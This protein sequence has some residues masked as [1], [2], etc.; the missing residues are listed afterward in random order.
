M[1]VKFRYHL[2]CVQSN[3]PASGSIW[4]WVCKGKCSDSEMEVRSEGAGRKWMRL[5]TA[6]EGRMSLPGPETAEEFIRK[7]KACCDWMPPESA[8]EIWR[9]F[10]SPKDIT[11]PSA[12]WNAN[13]HLIITWNADDYTEMWAVLRPVSPCFPSFLVLELNA[14]GSTCCFPQS[15]APQQQLMTS[16]RNFLKEK[17]RDDISVSG[18][19][20]IN[21]KQWWKRQLHKPHIAFVKRLICRIRMTSG[22]LNNIKATPRG[23][24]RVKTGLKC[25]HSKP[26]RKT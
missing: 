24:G 12:M 20:I 22:L 8:E 23:R 1:T 21:N 25:C 6:A 7:V 19:N 14:A 5:M 17:Q 9:Q 26:S 13:N 16:C 11:K 4:K 18:E 10:N 15:L 2:I 3:T